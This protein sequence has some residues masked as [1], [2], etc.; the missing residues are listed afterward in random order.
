MKWQGLDHQTQSQKEFER[1]TG[2]LKRKIGIY[3]WRKTPH[4]WLIFNY[5]FPGKSPPP[6]PGQQLHTG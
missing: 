5:V 6:S 4:E 3:R 1:K 2:S